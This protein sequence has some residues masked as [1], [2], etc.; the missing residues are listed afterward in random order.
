MN[1]MN[2]STDFLDSIFQKSNEK[3]LIMTLEGL[4]NTILC[5]CIVARGVMSVLKDSVEFCK[6]QI[7][8]VEELNIVIIQIQWMI[9]SIRSKKSLSESQSDRIVIE[10]IIEKYRLHKVLDDLQESI[11]ANRSQ[12]Y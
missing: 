3:E 5:K 1:R 12:F 11:Q 7:S 9:I 6:K 4:N 10:R 2:T 8:L